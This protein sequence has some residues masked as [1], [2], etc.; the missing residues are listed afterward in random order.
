MRPYEYFLNQL[1]T[2]D[3]SLIDEEYNF[4]KTT[5]L[6]YVEKISL[7][8]T[9]MNLPSGSRVGVLM[10]KSALQILSLLSLWKNDL[11]YV[12]ISLQNP[13]DRLHYILENSELSL[14]LIKE[15]IAIHLKSLPSL[16][17]KDLIEES[18]EVLSLSPPKEVTQTISYII[19]TSGT[20]GLPKGAVISNLAI[21]NFFNAIQ[22]EFKLRWNQEVILQMVDFSFDVSFWD[23]GLWLIFGGKLVVT[24]FQGNIINLLKTVLEN[25]TTVLTCAAPTY[26]ILTSSQNLLKRYDLNFIRLLITTASYC[27]P[28]VALDIL[29]LVP[30]AQLYNCYG[31]TEA[32]V[33]CTWTEIKKDDI[34]LD[35]PLSIGKLL[36]GL[37]AAF[38]KDGEFVAYDKHPDGM[39]AE[40]LIAGPQLFE[41]YWKSSELTEKKIF[42]KNDKKY[43]FTGDLV[44]KEK[45][46]FYYFGRSDD[47]IKVN[48]YRINLGEIEICICQIQEIA[49]TVI[50]EITNKNL[51][52]ELYSFFT[53][54][55]N[56]SNENYSEKVIKYCKSQLP[57][58]MVPQKCIQLDSFPLSI[59][60]KINKK[61]LKD[62][63]TG[64][65]C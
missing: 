43:Y 32:T 46:L 42:V 58:Y 6:S 25:K 61:E 52:T 59:A 30:S 13:A 23:I 26:A 64:G 19:Y 27:P 2:K 1:E 47:T 49:H 65:E 41:H 29:D 17:I 34:Q 33:Y 56:F 48:G 24:N 53:V 9:R 40:L 35:R 20:T 54:K 50:I 55:N 18:N 51:Q 45:D 21:T 11:I 62:R 14:L 10:G 36:T 16:N 28:K 8:L 31:P 3:L 7:K 37:E 22:N 63:I 38:F 15:P 44:T 57:S 60:G 12:P 4:D 5:I 39:E